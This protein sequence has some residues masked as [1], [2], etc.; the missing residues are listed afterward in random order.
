LTLALDQEIQNAPPQRKVRTQREVHGHDV[1]HHAA[2]PASQTACL[3][4]TSH[5]LAASPH[6]TSTM[7]I[8]AATR[9]PRRWRVCSHS[10]RSHPPAGGAGARGRSP[11]ETVANY[12]AEEKPKRP[13]NVQI[14]GVNALLQIPPPCLRPFRTDSP[15]RSIVP[16]TGYVRPSNPGFV[17]RNA[18]P[19]SSRSRVKDVFPGD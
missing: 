6:R 11:R 9:S 4:A 16:C 12:C 1:A 5:R 14:S 7:R 10:N 17:K 19:A 2:S 18:R 13:Q 3:H 15:S 8:P